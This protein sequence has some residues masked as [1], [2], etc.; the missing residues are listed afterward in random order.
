MTTPTSRTVVTVKDNALTLGHLE[1]LV[2][3]AKA[4]GCTRE[5]TAKLMPKSR[6]LDMNGITVT[7]ELPELEE[8]DPV[9]LPARRAAWI[10]VDTDWR[11]LYVLHTG[12]LLGTPDPLHLTAPIPRPEPNTNTE[13]LD[14]VKFAYRVGTPDSAYLLD[15]YQDRETATGWERVLVFRKLTELDAEIRRMAESL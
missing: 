6:L 11:E 10:L 7:Q 14:R 1:D 12:H 8:H 5:A 9:D 15:S 13:I 3:E 2:A 4:R